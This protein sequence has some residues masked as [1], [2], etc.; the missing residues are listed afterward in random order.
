MTLDVADYWSAASFETKMRRLVQRA[1]PASTDAPP[2]LVAFPEDVGLMLV[3]QGMEATL[4]GAATLSEAVGKVTRARLWPTLWTRLR[5]RVGWV[6]ALFLE[7]HATI[8]ETY[9]GTFA[10]LAR[11]FG[12][13]IVA[14]SVVL[15]PYAIHDGQVDW[16]SGP[17]S[18]R[19]HNTSYLFAPDGRVVGKQ[20]KAYLIEIEEALSL[21]PGRTDDLQVLETPLGR[22]GIAICFDAFQGPVNERL[23]A[24]GAQILVQPSANPGPWDTDQQIDWLRSAYH[25]TCEAQHFT[26]AVNPMMNGALWD[27]EFFGQSSILT[28]H[29]E[30]TTPQS[31]AD[32]PHLSG[33]LRLAATDRDEDVLVAQ[34]AHP[35]SVVSG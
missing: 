17:L 5:R 10:K 14:G 3:L 24:Q 29:T 31:Y 34:V 11:E 27:L 32:L 21:T 7:R 35:D 9:F 15:P 25:Q 16:R 1:A 8:A 4:A 30:D 12:V 19:V 2:T 23:R 22:V 33:F 13:W 6:P 26:Y 28:R 20:D 18:H